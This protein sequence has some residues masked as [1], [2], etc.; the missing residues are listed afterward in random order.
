MKLTIGEPAAQEPMDSAAYFSWKSGDGAVWADFFRRGD[1]YLIRFPH[2][3]D[4]EI[5]AHADAVDCSPAPGTETGTLQHLFLNQVLPLALN[6]QGKIVLHASAVEAPGGAVAFAGVSGR[7]KSTL[8]ASFAA[9]GTGFLTDDALVVEPDDGKGCRAW[10]SDPSIRLWNDMRWTLAGD[11]LT[12]PAVPITAKARVL[13]GAGLAFCERPRRLLRLYLLGDGSA[14]A[15][16]ITPAT[17]AEALLAWIRNGFLIDALDPDMLARQF[18]QA[19]RL[20]R[21]VDTYHLDFPRS[22]D[23][24]PEVRRAVQNHGR[25]VQ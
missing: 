7:G 17:Q 13:V 21:A 18:D 23:M 25:V 14:T 1:R 11:A 19:S 5:S 4:F 16:S 8:A 22:L 3:A 15:L 10:P 6:L 9:N 20:A 12:A 24:L 2:L